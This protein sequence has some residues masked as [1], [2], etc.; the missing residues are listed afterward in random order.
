VSFEAY[1]IRGD[2]HREYGAAY[3]MYDENGKVIHEDYY[4]HDVYH[5]LDGPAINSYEGNGRSWFIRGKNINLKK[6]PVVLG[7]SFYNFVPSDEEILDVS[8]NFDREYGLFL[9]KFKEEN[10]GS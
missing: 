8:L 1:N 4:Q 7:N 3:I 5:R 9:K 2:Y 6:I 10:Y